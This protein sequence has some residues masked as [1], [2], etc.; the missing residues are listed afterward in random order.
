M[1]LLAK[2]IDESTE[3]DSQLVIQ[4]AV[5][6]ELDYERLID[7]EKSQPFAIGTKRIGEHIGISLVVFSSRRAV[8]IPEAVELFGI[9]PEDREAALQQTL[10]E[11]TPAQLDSDGYLLRL[12]AQLKQAAGKL[13]HASGIMFN[14]ELGQFSPLRVEDTDLMRVVGPVDTCEQSIPG[15]HIWSPP[16]GGTRP[17]SCC[18]APVLALAAQLPTGCAPRTCPPGRRSTPGARGARAPYGVPGGRPVVTS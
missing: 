7:S 4:T 5:L 12:G 14:R 15:F 1:E 2:P 11:R 18:I 9:D 16:D 13:V 8:T 17:P 3:V 6:A 10:D